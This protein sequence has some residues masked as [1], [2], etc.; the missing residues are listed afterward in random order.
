M[1]AKTNTRSRKQKTFRQS[2][3]A[4][5]KRKMRM[6]R[7]AGILC[8]L[9]AIAS[10]VVYYLKY[11]NE[12]LNII[13]IA[14]SIATVFVANSFLQDIKVG[15]PWQR[16]NAVCGILLYIFTAFLIAWGFITGQLVTQF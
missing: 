1:G 7:I 16:V 15:N 8:C 2:Q 12:W 14:Y 6:S 5:Y 9:L 13:T 3:A 10:I 4:F 11:M